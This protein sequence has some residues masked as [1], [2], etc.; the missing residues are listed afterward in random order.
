[1]LFGEYQLTIY[2]IIAL[3]VLLTVLSYILRKTTILT[4]DKMIKQII[5]SVA[6]LLGIVLILLT[7]PITDNSKQTLLSFLGIL[8]GATIALSSTTF[9]ANGMS[10]MMLNL[11]RPFKT[12]DYIRIGDEF[13]K[14]SNISMLHTQIQSIDRDL[15]NIPNLKLVSNPL[16]TI[17]TSGTIISATVSLGY[18]TPWKHIEKDLI[19]AAERTEL[20]SPFVHVTE[21]NDH[22]VTY[23]VGGL[24]RDIS[25]L[26]T[27]RS[28]LKKA[29]IDALH[30]DDIEIVSPTFM[31]QRVYDKN[32]VF[33][34]SCPACDTKENVPAP[35]DEYV[36]K[37][38]TEDIIFDKAIGAELIK[39]IDMTMESLDNKIAEF[40]S[41]FSTT[42]NADIFTSEQE[43]IGSIENQKAELG[44]SF[45]TMK[46]TFEKEDDK[47]PD[48]IKLKTLQYVDSRLEE[49]DNGMEKL[50]EKLK[51]NID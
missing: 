21:L 19:R 5:L 23:K 31:N 44:N 7:L 47:T 38:S 1:M 8:L 9:V 37:M 49:M 22:A 51:E 45:K 17:S 39:K 13:G 40:R 48:A 27:K 25:G 32:A 36:P 46:E 12:G 34:P 43:E 4:R 29:V 2:T 3:F 50:L 41:L 42:P 30:E 20:E 35:S 11:I 26:I 10:G 18:D 14:V 33:I 15:I 16:V 24:L 6:T 28:D